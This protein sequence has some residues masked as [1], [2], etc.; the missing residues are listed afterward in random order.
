[1]IE[2]GYATIP[3]ALARGLR[4]VRLNAVVERIEYPHVDRAPAASAAAAGA[5]AA[6]R[7][8]IVSPSGSASA[9]ETIDADAVVVTLPIGC[10]KSNSVAFEPPLPLWK[11]RA[12]ANMGSGVQN[13]VALVFEEPFWQPTFARNADMF[14]RIASCGASDDRGFLFMFWSLPDRGDSGG[15]DDTID[16]EA[17]EE[18]EDEEEEEEEAAAELTAPRRGARARVKSWKLGGRELSSA[19]AE[20]VVAAV[21]APVPPSSEQKA[22]LSTTAVGGQRGGVSVGPRRSPLALNLLEKRREPACGFGSEVRKEKRT[23]YS[24]PVPLAEGVEHSA[25]NTEMEMEM[26]TETET[27]T[28]LQ[29][30]TDV[31]TGAGGATQGTPLAKGHVLIALC[32]GRSARAIEALSDADVVARAVAALREMLASRA[33]LVPEPIDAVVTRW[34]SDKYARG[35]YSFVPVGSTGVE[36]DLLAAPVGASLL[37]AGEATN[38]SHPTSC[39]GALRSGLREAARIARLRGRW[40]DDGVLRACAVPRGED[41]W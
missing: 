9:R 40:R 13:K 41:W 14:G 1:M 10:L 25:A 19:A 16:A 39:H 27:E 35:A 38:R 24:S 11:R 12:I 3:N 7:V 6:V 8:S 4:D 18:D 26:E 15:A 21:A 20:S 28:C 33:I 34:G 31:E 2:R 29:M 30:E 32:V 36:Y 22:T 37:F 17:A 23:P 5:P